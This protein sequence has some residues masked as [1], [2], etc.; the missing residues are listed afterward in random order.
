MRESEVIEIVLQIGKYWYPASILAFILYH[1]CIGY[2]LY[3]LV[4]PL[5]PD[6]KN[7]APIL[8]FYS[9]VSIF[10]YTVFKI[11]EAKRFLQ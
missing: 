4:Y 7:A 2:V 11:E 8:I 6:I 5:Y 9:A 1:A 3:D 10:Y